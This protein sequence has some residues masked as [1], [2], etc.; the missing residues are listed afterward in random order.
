VTAVSAGWPQ[1]AVVIPDLDGAGWYQRLMSRCPDCGTELDHC[2]G[3]L[4]AHSDGTLDCTDAA[5]LVADPMRH[6]LIIDCA[7]VLGGCCDE[8]R[9]E[10]F[11]RAS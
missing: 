3:T 2:H 9:T 4:I 10:D 7:A 5:C 6:T 11:A 8:P 1:H